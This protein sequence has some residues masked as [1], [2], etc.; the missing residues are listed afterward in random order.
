[1]L[2]TQEKN[3]IIDKLSSSNILVLTTPPG[4]GK[5][6]ILPEEFMNKGASV[7]VVEQNSNIE[8]IYNRMYTKL[9]NKIKINTKENKYITYM[10][11]IYAE[12][13][14]TDLLH[15]SRKNN[16]FCDILIINDAS[17]GKETI[18]III[19][20]WKYLYNKGTK[21]PK[22]LLTSSAFDFDKLNFKNYDLYEITRDVYPI[23]I[24]YEIDLNHYTLYE[25]TARRVLDKHQQ[26]SPPLL[27]T[28]GNI[29]LVFCP[30]SNEVKYVCDLLEKEND[31]YLEILPYYSE[32]DNIK[33]NRINNP[34]NNNHRRIIVST[35]ILET[36]VTIDNL[37]GVFDTLTERLNYT[38]DFGGINLELKAIS[39]FSAIE[40]AGRTG[41][42]CPGFVHRMC[43]EEYYNSLDINRVPE[44]ERIPIY[45]TIIK[46]MSLKLNPIELLPKLDRKEFEKLKLYDIITDD[47]I[48]D[49]G[50]FI[51]KFPVF[52]IKNSILLYR[53]REIE[54]PI[55]PCL[56]TICLIESYGKGYFNDQKIEFIRFSENDQGN[57]I[58]ALLNFWFEFSSNNNFETIKHRQIIDYC[59]GNGLNEKNFVNLIMSLRKNI[60]IYEKTFKEKIEITPFDVNELTDI[61]VPVVK[62][63]AITGNNILTKSKNIYKDRNG[64]KYQISSIKGNKIIPL[65]IFGDNIILS[66]NN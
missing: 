37:S 48:T 62:D 30:G 61:I 60:S 28:E 58:T 40:R 46:L 23:K 41:R 49:L 55:F 45:H 43:T 59:I 15:S 57:D 3:D 53:W 18:N 31:P 56:L 35:N 9:G 22:L 39:K 47:D 11:D 50:Q 33:K 38:S 52:S 24:T 13:M 10:T 6:T 21:L 65:S 2:N 16:V 20:I 4:I 42:T 8:N 32:L 34:I 36:S 17:S 26:N 29:W 66:I 14:M 19:S 64:N 7:I 27:T 44:I 63:I 12:K 51:L 1:M 5:S 25:I 54:Y